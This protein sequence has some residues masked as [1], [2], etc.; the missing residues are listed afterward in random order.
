M[1]NDSASQRVGSRPSYLN[2]GAEPSLCDGLADDTFSK[3]SSII[4]CI[5]QFEIILPK[6]ASMFVLSLL[7]DYTLESPSNTSNDYI[8]Y[9][10][11][12]CCAGSRYFND[13]MLLC[14]MPGHRWK[15][16]GLCKIT[17]EN[18]VPR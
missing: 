12:L 4:Y 9:V 14:M 16:K 13:Q 6:V 2:R 10:K 7:W 1:D 3:A 11:E 18:N 17:T 5:T 8:T 15:I